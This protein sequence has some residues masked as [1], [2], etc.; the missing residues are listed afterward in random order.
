MWIKEKHRPN[1]IFGP[2][3]PCRRE[4]PNNN[5]DRQVK[6]RKKGVNA[7]NQVNPILSH[8]VM[9]SIHIAKDMM[10]LS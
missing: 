1:E 8:A 9:S 4:E 10:C 7:P 3:L 5:I 6:E 2:L